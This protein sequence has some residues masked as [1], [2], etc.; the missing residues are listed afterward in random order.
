MGSRLCALLRWMLLSLYSPRVSNASVQYCCRQKSEDQKYPRPQP[1]Y[2]LSLLM[3]LGP[4]NSSRF[5]T[6]SKKE[7]IMKQYQ[8]GKI[9]YQT[10]QE[11]TTPR[12]GGVKFS[13]RINTSTM[14]RQLQESSRLP[15]KMGTYGSMNMST[16]MGSLSMS[17]SGYSTMN[18]TMNS[19]GVS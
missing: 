16:S 10:F 14:G 7:R 5:R 12:V 8:S 15:S 6:G 4:R 1:S 3:S 17:S 2:L 11:L 19:T 18:S 13:G 9:N